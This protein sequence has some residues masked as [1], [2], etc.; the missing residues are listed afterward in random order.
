MLIV[1]NVVY[2]DEIDLH[3]L[4]ELVGNAGCAD[5]RGSWPRP[6]SAYWTRLDDVGNV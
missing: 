3:L 5:V 4:V 6:L 2:L 1:D